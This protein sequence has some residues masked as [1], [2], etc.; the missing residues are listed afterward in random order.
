VRISLQTTVDYRKSTFRKKYL[1][2]WSKEIYTVSSIIPAQLLSSDKFTVIDQDGNYTKRRYFRY[3]LQKI[4]KN[5]LIPIK[6]NPII[7]LPSLYTNLQNKNTI[8]TR[9]QTNKQQQNLELSE[10]YGLQKFY[11]DTTIRLPINLQSSIQ[12]S[13]QI[14]VQSPIQS[15]IQIP[16][17][18]CKN[19]SFPP[20]LR[21][22]AAFSSFT[23][24][25]LFFYSSFT[26]LSLFFHFTLLSLFFL[27]PFS[28]ITFNFLSNYF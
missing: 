28:L 16:I 17:Q 20:K 23:L 6:S 2:Q 3:Q 8:I 13:I 25:S 19:N 5:T 22:Y 11:I 12:S 10:K 1:S 21:R 4:N 7:V 24:F 14:P 26:L 9:S 18:N 15:P 27:S